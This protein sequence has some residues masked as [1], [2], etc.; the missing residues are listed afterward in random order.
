MT[1]SPTNFMNPLEK[2]IKQYLKKRIHGNGDTIRI[3]HEIQ[4]LPYAGFFEQISIGK[5][6]VCP[7]DYSFFHNSVCAWVGQKHLKLLMFIV[8]ERKKI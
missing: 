4:C 5:L 7:K 1:Q 3:G 2:I 8:K 6:S